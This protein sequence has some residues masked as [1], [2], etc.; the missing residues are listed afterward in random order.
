MCVSPTTGRTVAC[1][2]AG[3]SRLSYTSRPASSS[4]CCFV[5]VRSGLTDNTPVALWRPQSQDLKGSHPVT[6]I[7]VSSP[8]R[9]ASVSSMRGD[10]ARV[11]NAFCS[12]LE[13]E[14]WR[15]EREVDFCDVRATRGTEL[16]FAEAKGRTAAP[17]L[18]IDTLYG[19]LLRRVPADAV[20]V[21]Q[22]AVVVPS[23]ALSAALRVPLSVREALGIEIY[24]VDEFSS[25]VHHEG[26]SG[27]SHE[28]QPL[29]SRQIEWAHLYNG[30]ERLA[31]GE[32][33]P[34]ALARLLEPAWREYQLRGRVPE[35]CGVDLLRG[36]AFY[37][38]RAD[39]HGGGYDLGEGGGKVREWNAVLERIATHPGARREDR[40]P[41]EGL[42]P[43]A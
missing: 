24:T 43:S 26:D 10:E 31:G 14:G 16:M 18:D 21:A 34:Q 1:I 42:V 19:Q 32:E 29:V 28:S 3:R 23:T 5:R 39:R 36:W 27:R 8:P 15:V 37:L 30:Y 7:E 22:F 6:L 11:V 9:R 40:P 25:V 13:S 33:G 35:W 17:G 2:S 20:G 4:P 38:T 12:W 41:L